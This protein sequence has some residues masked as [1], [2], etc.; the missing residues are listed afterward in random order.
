MLSLK[1]ELNGSAHLRWN[2]T[3]WLHQ[4]P[5]SL[6]GDIFKLWPPL[7]KVPNKKPHVLNSSM[8]FSGGTSGKEHACQCR[9]RKRCGF[10]PWMGKMP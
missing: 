8:G 5:S 10:D 3:S 1:K 7:T 6:K 2:R 9:R 4:D